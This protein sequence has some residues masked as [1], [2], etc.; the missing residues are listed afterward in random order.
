MRRLS[1]IFG[2]ALPFVAPA[3]QET[4]D[5]KA[6]IL[7]NETAYIPPQCYTKTQDD[8]GQVHNPCYVCHTRS[9]RPNYVND[10][11]LQLAYSFP[12]VAEKNPWTNL[13]RDRSA[14]VAAI[15]DQDILT[16]I[17]KSNYLD[18]NGRITP[19][20]RLAHLPAAWDYNG[21]GR[22]QGFVPDAWFNF[23]AEGFDRT[24]A[25]KL[26]GWR[27]FA[28]Q[29][30][31]G[32]F[33]P[34]NGSTDDVLIRLPEMFRRDT[35]GRPDPAVY[36][37]NLAIVEAMIR[38]ADVPIA[39]AD[40]AALGGV[41][42]D[43]DGTVGTARLI[44]YDWAPLQQRYMWYVGQALA[45]QRAGEVHLAAGL[46]PEGTE[47]LHTVRYIDPDP[48]GANRLSARIKEVRYARKRF[49]MNYGRLEARAAKEMKQKV[50]FPDRLRAIRGNLEGGVSN[51]QGWT[52]AAMIEDADGELRP[53]SFE[54]LAFCVGCHGGIGA[55]TDSSFAFPRKLPAGSHQDG[56]YHWS[57]KDLRGLP[58]RL[59]RDGEP[60]YAYYLTAN[61]AG[62]EYRANSE[63]QER[64]FDAS[65]HLRQD[66]L[67]QLRHDVSALLYASPARALQLNKAYRVIVQEQS[68]HLGRD[69]TVT[70][71]QNVHSEV[72]ERTT[73]GVAKPLAGR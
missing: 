49:W 20:E 69:P 71:A 7:R 8:A 10:D 59:R 73:T 63:V 52:Y 39:P 54:E 16:Y 12:L 27:V 5:L 19:A 4:L 62:D 21:D 42:L 15:S 33:W 43:K 51:E 46:Y 50:A 61:G 66:R 30:F 2:L 56:W 31:L 13:F 45:A 1:L 25:G 47:F 3:A 23:D 17:R 14:E 38:E 6:S 53:Q 48:N 35:E 9:R 68:F 11:E 40:E 29:P 65:G 34:T 70:P 58:E 41:D 55:T 24:P 64:F 37:T 28:Y 67:E 36:N 26:T 60:E 72:D 32:T 57:Q 22:W 18:A 44:K